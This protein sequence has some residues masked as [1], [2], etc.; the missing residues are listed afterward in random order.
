MRA[1]DVNIPEP[2]PADWGAMSPRSGGTS[3]HCDLCRKD[4]HD[5]SAMG[6]Q[7]A[8]AFLERCGADVCVSYL[9][10]DT[11]AVRF[12]EPPLIPASAL[13]PRRRASRLAPMTLGLA[14]AACT[15]HG[16]V[17]GEHL[18]VEELDLQ[19]RGGEVIDYGYA[20]PAVEHPPAELEEPCDPEPA[21]EDEPPVEERRRTKG[22]RVRRTA[23]KPIPPKDDGRIQ[24]LLDL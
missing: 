2:C 19:L 1:D 3:R 18:E 4:V 21:V 14:L 23:G 16:T 15:P 5:L 6:E 10:D 22:K 13:R 11:G 12:Q 17:Q 9:A 24:G 8:R 7:A 20:A